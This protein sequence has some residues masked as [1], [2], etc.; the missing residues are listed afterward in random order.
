MHPRILKGVNAFP[1][2]LKESTTSQNEPVLENQRQVVYTEDPILL[3]TQLTGLDT[4]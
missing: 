4:E 1:L 3:A 2:R